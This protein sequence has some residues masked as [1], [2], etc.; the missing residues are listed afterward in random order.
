MGGYNETELLKSWQEAQLS[1][2]GSDQ[3]ELQLP[4]NHAQLP[5][6][7]NYTLLLNILP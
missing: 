5:T 4:K 2:I 7:S 6:S 1:K 3:D